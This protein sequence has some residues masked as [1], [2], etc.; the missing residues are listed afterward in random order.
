[1][2]R[3]GEERP[4]LVPFERFFAV[5]GYVSFCCVL[6][7]FLAEVASRVAVPVYRHFKLPYRHFRSRGGTLFTNAYI[8]GISASPAYDG[9]A[10]AEDFWKEQ[11]ARW[12]ELRTSF[13][14]YEPFRIWGTQ[15]DRGKYIN[16]DNTEMGAMRRT[17][18]ALQPGCDKQTG[19]KIWFFGASTSWGYGVPDFA[20]IPSYLSPR[21]NAGS[22][23][24]V[25][26]INLGVDGYNT[27]QE[28]IYL[29]QKLKAGW[30]PDV[31]IFYDGFDEAA[32][33]SSEPGLPEAHWFYRDIKAKSESSILSWPDLV[34]RSYFL[35]AITYLKWRYQRRRAAIPSDQEW[36]VR[37]RAD[38]D[39]Y[40][41]NRRLVALLCSEYGF[42]AYFFWQPCI[43][44]GDKPLVPYEQAI[45]EVPSVHAD[46]AAIRAVYEEADRRSAA[47]GKFIFLG[48]VFD[49]VKEPVYI[50]QVHLGPRGNE[51][52]AGAIAS[53]IQ[54]SLIKRSSSGR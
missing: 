40:E 2:R 52:I 50:D 22:G 26:V 28:A 24:C 12:E 29:T 5:L 11:R 23:S 48:R 8:D 32:I 53:A 15:L 31:V 45:T 54:P 36:A 30:R 7:F 1:M 47:S 33:G 49:G 25:E 21:L 41:S 46:Y 43:M 34:K 20:T 4:G 39:N 17:V 18:N 42:D 6:M 10:W 51:I 9:Y 13:Y 27:N 38:M 3:E 37:A 35:Q 14:P 16:V 44:Y 19:I